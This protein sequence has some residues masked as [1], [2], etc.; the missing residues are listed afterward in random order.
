MFSLFF[1]TRFILKSRHHNRPIECTHASQ[2]SPG[3]T[4]GDRLISSHHQCVGK[5][6]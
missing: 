5:T 2:S 6:L 4:S 1:Q 3:Q